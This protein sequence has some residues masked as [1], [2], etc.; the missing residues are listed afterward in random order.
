[1]SSL[2][3]PP[4][5]RNQLSYYD[6]KFLKCR[7]HIF[8]KQHKAEVQEKRL[9]D[10]KDMEEKIYLCGR[11]A[12]YSG[13]KHTFL[14]LLYYRAHIA[15]PNERD[16]SKPFSEGGFDKVTHL[17]RAIVKAAESLN[18]PKPAPLFIPSYDQRRLFAR[19]K[20]EEIAKQL[21]PKRAP[22]PA[23]LPPPDDAEVDALL[24]KKGVISKI[25][26]EQVI[27]KDL[28]RLQ[29]GQ[30]LNDEI[31][32]FYGQMVMARSEGIKVNSTTALVQRHE[33]KPPKS[34]ALDVHYFS[35]FFWTKLKGEGYE[36][37]RLAKWTKKFDL[38]AKDIV[39]IPINH[40][41]SHWTCAAINF[42][43][44]RIEAY[45]SMNLHPGHVFKVC[46]KGL[47]SLLGLSFVSKQILRHYL[48]L[49]H[50]SKKKKPFDFGGWEDYSSG[51]TPQQENGSDCGVFTCQFLA[52][53]ARGEESFRFTQQDMLYLRR[54]MIWEIGHAE[55]RED[56]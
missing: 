20:D 26:R 19:E 40:N 32:N 8:D 23:A 47:V 10:R 39:L 18:G 45:D 28:C 55:L 3:S 46:G 53:L 34:Q 2:P 42:R 56:V 13:D 44:K 4:S 54:R 27:D 21:P 5:Q 12:G 9:L 22:L 11:D 15:D 52:S 48:D 17:Q 16:P 29:P 50:R 14:E 41:N 6:M 49:E 35:T 36:R 1:M 51:D 31:I 24:A 43:R 38:F 30:W 33:R 25:F 7:M 37:A